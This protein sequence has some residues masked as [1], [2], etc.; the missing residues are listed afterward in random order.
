MAV[1]PPRQYAQ[2]ARSGTIGEILP[3][4][5]EIMEEKAAAL[6]RA[7]EKAE[8]CLKR[9]RECDPE[10]E[11]RP[12]RLSEAARAVYAYFIQRE[13]CGLRRHRDVIREYAI[14]DEV[15]ARLGAM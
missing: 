7:G 1:R 15:L 3:L 10:S 13:L 11:E 4:D 2:S 14:P 8:L 9:L 5:H 12:Q 6:G